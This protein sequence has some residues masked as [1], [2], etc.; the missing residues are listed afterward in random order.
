M[1]ITGTELDVPV[2]L[3]LYPA[4]AGTKATIRSSSKPHLNQ[5]VFKAPGRHM[6]HMGSLSVTGWL[7]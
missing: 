6:T 3:A 4:R 5:A 7:C 2:E 1:L